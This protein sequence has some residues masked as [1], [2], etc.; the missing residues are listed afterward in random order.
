MS[1]KT[2]WYKDAVV[3]HIYPLSFMDSNNDGIG[4]LRG[5][6]SRLDHI[7]E[8]GATAI[9]LSPVYP[10]PWKDYG[11]DIS[12]YRSIHPALGTM[13]DFEDLV[14]EC[15]A[16]GMKLM[17]DAVFNHTSD[18]HEWFKA[19]LSDRNSPYRDY[20]IFR[21]G[22]DGKNGELLPP[23]NW[24]S[25]FTG[26]AWERIA[27]TD[28]YYLHLFTPEQPDLNWEN[29]KVREELEDILAF[30]LDKGVDG[31]RF[32]VFNL[33]S[34]TYPL[35]DDKNPLSFQKGTKYFVDG[36]RIHEFLQELNYRAFSKYDT[37]TVGESYNP[38][39]EHAH[40]Y[41]H[42]E[43]GEL[44]AIFDF[45]H[46][47]SDNL[48]GLKM[49]PKPFSLRQFKR[50]L[51]GPQLR[52]QGSGWNT[53]VLENHDNA[54]CVSRFGINTG[55]FR[56][57]AATFLAMITYFG[58]GTPF[59]YQGQE[60]GMTNS[61][62]KSLDDMKDP[63][64]A[65]VYNTMREKHIPAAAAFKM[66]RNGARDNSRTPMQW[67]ST[68]NAGFNEGAEPWQ[69]V[70]PNYKKINV[71]ADLASDRSIY[72]F[73]Q[74]VLGLR[75]SIPALMNGSTIEY[76]PDDIQVVSYSRSLEGARFLIV[77][78]FSGTRADFIMPGDF[79]LDELSVRFTNLDRTDDGIEEIM[80][81]KPY[82]AL[83]LE[84]KRR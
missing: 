69:A 38:D 68:A 10:S 24:N 81:L 59:I 22:R 84:E 50:G 56:Y 44:D 11:Y 12:D 14:A 21:K 60:I 58:W 78:N 13:E 53:L 18:Q 29:P 39:A 66:L 46:L 1:E 54:R 26:P 4:D 40:R 37:F 75:R 25:S 65:F 63:V 73:Y 15:H 76:Y 2:N 57:E 45:G 67:S 77:G 51:I 6:I 70:N 35:C 20:Y 27:G 31:F 41:I 55:R 30:W 83:L 17:M 32:D 48:F 23:T 74:E 19:A 43:S 47:A 72:R 49:I 5:I 28:E 16:R 3:Y 82:E 36:P 9:W 80:Q 33:Y 8:L 52:Y 62:F 7:Q 34:K 79:E 64:S 61:R 42:E 71:E